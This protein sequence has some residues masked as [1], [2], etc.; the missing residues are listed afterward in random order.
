M[1][2]DELREEFEMIRQLIAEYKEDFDTQEYTHLCTIIKND[3]EN[4][5]KELMIVNNESLKFYIAKEKELARLKTS[6]SQFSPVQKLIEIVRKL[7]ISEDTE[8][9]ILNKV[10]PNYHQNGVRMNGSLRK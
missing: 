10:A 2:E 9:M 8:R 1:G 3:L 5:M 7:K 6:I 4:D